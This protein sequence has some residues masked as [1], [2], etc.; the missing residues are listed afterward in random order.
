M[1]ARY[2]DGKK[3]A[4][5]E[6]FESAAAEIQKAIDLAPE[7]QEYA[8]ALGRV[9]RAWASW[10]AAS[11]Q[12][13]VVPSRRGMALVDQVLAARPAWPDARV[14]RASLLLT[15]AEAIRGSEAQRELA[16]RAAADF[17]S[18][19]SANPNLEHAWR[20]EATRAEQLSAAR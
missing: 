7:N 5:S 12:D 14:L 11:G 3:L 19:L 6:D 17:K 1:R 10:L 2:L 18:A 15:Q 4:R 16:A 9:C 13:P 20:S 8:L